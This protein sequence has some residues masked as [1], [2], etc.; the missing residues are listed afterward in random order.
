MFWKNKCQRCGCN[1]IGV[2]KESLLNKLARLPLYFLFFITI[3]FV[4]GKRDQ[5]VCR[6]C[7]FTWEK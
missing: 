5:Y 1:D 4:K 7:G 3:F 2:I 6:K